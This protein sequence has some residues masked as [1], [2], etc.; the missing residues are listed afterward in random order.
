MKPFPSFVHSFISI[1]VCLFHTRENDVAICKM[2]KQR[3]LLSNDKCSKIDDLSTFDNVRKE[4]HRH[5]EWQMSCISY[6]FSDRF[7]LDFSHARLRDVVICFYSLL[8]GEKKNFFLRDKRECLHGN[9]HR[10]RHQHL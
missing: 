9:F 4:P 8:L 6:C 3:L 5:V 7:L 10:R 1:Y 2:D